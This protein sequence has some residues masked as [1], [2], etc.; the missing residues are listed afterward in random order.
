MD[1][2]GKKLTSST[3][4]SEWRH[5]D[6]KAKTHYSFNEFTGEV[7]SRVYNSEG[8]LVRYNGKHLSS[9]NSQYQTNIVLQLSD[10]ETVRN[11]TNALTSKHPDNSYIAKM[12]DNGKLTVYDLS[13]NEVSLNVNGKYRINVVA[14]GS[15]MA[16]IGAEQL[17]T[18][19]TD[20]Q[21][22]LR[23]EQ[24]EQGRIALVGCETDKPSSSGTST[25]ITSLA[26]L[27]AQRLYDGGNGTI[28]AEVTGRTTQIEVN[29]NG[30]K[31]MLTG[32][33]K[34]VYSWDTDKGG[35]S[36]KTET[37]KNHSEALKNPLINLN[38]EIQRLEELL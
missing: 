30:T 37:V 3:G 34:T 13:G 11:A 2:D 24:T 15:E 21:T 12:N 29:A 17:A 23:I 36:Q 25:E 5:K 6:S 1:P 20:L 28:N 4:T 26:Q 32:G 33:T 9:N 22:K 31:T 7:E 27:V 38:E 18:Y 8:T 14:H 10:N 35:I 16:A 19:I